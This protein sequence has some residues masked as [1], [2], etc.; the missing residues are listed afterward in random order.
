M[1]R[2]ITVVLF[3]TLLVV[4][5]HA[6][7]PAADD[8][9]KQTLIIEF[10]TVSGQTEMFDQMLNQMFMQLGQGKSMTDEEMA[11]LKNDYIDILVPVYA[12]HFTSD[13]IKEMIK[14]YNSPIGKK[15]VSVQPQIM[16][17]TMLASQGWAM[18]L[19]Q[20]MANP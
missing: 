2:K 9:E 18:K 16:Q 11:E 20:K 15:Q 14:F 6:E 13:D 1:I 19:Q 10:F 4:T 8:A 7:Q 12:K 3:L 17:D 5:A